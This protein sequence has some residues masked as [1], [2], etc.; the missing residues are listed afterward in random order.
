MGAYYW[1]VILMICNIVNI[2]FGLTGLSILSG[3]GLI[4]IF[5]WYVFS[6]NGD[7]GGCWFQKW[8][9]PKDVAERGGEITIV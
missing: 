6:R 5:I 7:G 1:G 8:R 9:E 2:F 3:F 4:A